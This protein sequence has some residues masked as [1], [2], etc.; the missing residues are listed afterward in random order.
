[1]T[2][3]IKTRLLIAYACVVA[4]FVIVGS[5]GNYSRLL[6]EEELAA[7]AEAAVETENIQRLSLSIERVLMPAN[8]YLI[9]GDESERER[10]RA[11]TEELMARVAAYESHHEDIISGELR[12]K[13][14]VMDERAQAIFAL[15]RRAAPEHSE[16]AALM[17]SMDKAGE[18]AYLFLEGHY[19]EDRRE[20]R[21]LFAEADRIMV[22]LDRSMLWG[23]IV[24]LVLGVFF[25]FYLE[26]SIRV[27][28]EKLSAGV[29]GVA[30]G[31]WKRIDMGGSSSHGSEISVLATEFN[32]MVDKLQSS[33]DGLEKK[34][35][36]R[37][38]ELADANSK[39]EVLAVTDGLTGLFNHRHFY[40]VLEIELKRAERYGHTL[41]LLMIDI[42]DFKRINDTYGHQF[43]DHVL[44]GIAASLVE[45]VRETDI[46][47]RFGGEEFAI[48]LPEI[49]RDGAV[50]LA[51]RIRE[52]VS[53]K[54]YR[55]T[56]SGQE[57]GQEVT[58]TISLGVASYPGDADGIDGLISKA[59]N[60]LYKAKGDGKD[61]V[62]AA[63]TS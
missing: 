14:A 47:S 31:D 22:F 51:E 2:L 42:D 54:S 33:Y 37:T 4:I 62:E 50:V 24:V 39:L 60:A 25:V 7:L 58:V 52:S 16:G 55:A 59:D 3:G 43:G 53:S 18:D 28:M 15:P 61:R 12:R 5:I 57:S 17:Y 36:E 32:S 20:H 29:K 26:R 8:D 49:D 41:A 21:E 27:P 11:R 48:V 63:W 23:G 30:A 10:Y 35:E 9:S 45:S 6:I 40:N 44:R 34:V 19:A 56:Q 1:M 46:V 38:A 13:L